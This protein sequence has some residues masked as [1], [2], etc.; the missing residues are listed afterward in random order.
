MLGV[1]QGWE[2]D[3]SQQDGGKS[4]RERCWNGS[5]Q[6]W[7][8]LV[9]VGF[10]KNAP[11]WAGTAPGCCSFSSFIFLFFSSSVPFSGA[12]FPRR[13]HAVSH[14]SELPK[15]LKSKDFNTV[16]P[17]NPLQQPPKIHL[18][19]CP[20]VPCPNFGLGRGEGAQGRDTPQG[21]GFIS[22]GGLFGYF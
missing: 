10:W 7:Q 4:P 11:G 15:E 1:K 2:G 22:A 14:R 13:G 3:F 18:R 8:A 6:P 19:G 12:A 17:Q 21:S 16:Q 20:Q 5:S 9:P